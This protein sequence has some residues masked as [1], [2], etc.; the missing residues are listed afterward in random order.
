[1]LPAG[2]HRDVCSPC[3]LV[4][5]A[6]FV[7]KWPSVQTA[8]IVCVTP[9]GPSHCSPSLCARFVQREM[10]LCQNPIQTRAGLIYAWTLH[11]IQMH[12]SYAHTQI[13][14]FGTVAHKGSLR[15]KEAASFLRALHLKREERHEQY[16]QLDSIRRRLVHTTC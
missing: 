8:C 2:L 3:V 4:S 14:E 13:K 10:R 12:V 16:C 11:C 9:A 5:W 7:S 6:F 1:M 15:R